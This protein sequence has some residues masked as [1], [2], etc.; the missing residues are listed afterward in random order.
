LGEEIELRKTY[1][2][3]FTLNKLKL[4]E[5]E[6][7]VMVENEDDKLETIKQVDMEVENLNC[8]D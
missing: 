3:Q 5:K 4:K 6:L 8:F 1:V 2:N 7:S